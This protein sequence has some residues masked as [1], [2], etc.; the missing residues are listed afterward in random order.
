LETRRIDDSSEI[1]SSDTP[2]EDVWSLGVTLYELLFHALPFSGDNEYEIAANA[3]LNVLSL[4]PDLDPEIATL[5][6]GMLKV[7][8]R[9]RL[10]VADV[11]DNPL[12]RGAPDLA[13]DLPEVRQS[14]DRTGSIRV[15][16]AMICPP[17][18]SFAQIAIAEGMRMK[19]AG[20]SP[21]SSP[22][23]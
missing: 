8:V 14:P 7:D 9:N 10:S 20:E 4:P 23:D 2:K 6:Q 17:D 16:E 15:I 12:I 5:V 11:M 18:F 13:E 3:R 21:V 19:L 22:P 1:S